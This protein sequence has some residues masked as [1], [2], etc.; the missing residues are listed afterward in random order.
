[1]LIVLDQRERQI[2]RLRFGLDR[3]SALDQVGAHFGLTRERIRQIEARALSK[4]RHP[5]THRRARERRPAKATTRGRSSAAATPGYRP[6]LRHRRPAR[7]DPR[8]RLLPTAVAGVAVKTLHLRLQ[9]TDLLLEFEDPFDAGDVDPS[10][11][12]GGDLAKSLY[13][14][15]AVEAGA[16]VA[17]TGFDQS[18]AL[19]E[20]EGLGREDRR[21]GDGDGEHALVKV[22]PVQQYHHR[23]EGRRRLG[24]SRPAR[25]RLG[26]AR[27]PSMV[28]SRDR[29]GPGPSRAEPWSR[30]V[31][32]Q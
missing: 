2:L 1:M 5:S 8:R 17:A 15:A 27:P 14:A 30:P 20:A 3:G 25:R 26:V 7:P 21:G 16:S 12:Q 18:L 9:E 24:S 4:L 13:V 29:R 32:G 23:I 19:V 6:Q 31:P 22:G 11:G 10:A 28:P